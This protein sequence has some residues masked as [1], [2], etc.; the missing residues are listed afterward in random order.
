[1]KLEAVTRVMMSDPNI[2]GIDPSEDRQ[3]DA[4]NQFVSNE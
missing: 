4:A 2:T 3:Q 1:V